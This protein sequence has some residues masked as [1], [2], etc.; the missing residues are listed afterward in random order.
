MS[1]YVFGGAKLY[2]L[3]YELY[4]NLLFPKTI[5]PLVIDLALV[6]IDPKSHSIHK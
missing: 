5:Q 6:C 4:T 2:T 1:C 3:S